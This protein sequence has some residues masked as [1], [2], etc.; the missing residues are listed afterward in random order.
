[1]KMNADLSHWKF[2]L[3][4][5]VLGMIM[6][7]SISV[8][9]KEKASDIFT[10]PKVAELVVAASQGNA[11]EI[12][13]LVAEGVDVNARGENDI[14]PLVFAVSQKNIEGVAR[15]LH[16]G[17]DP[18]LFTYKGRY[19]VM[20]NFV[21]QKDPAYLEL[22][23]DYGGDVNAL[24]GGESLIFEAITLGR[25]EH[26]KILM[27]A[28]ADINF[29][30]VVGATPLHIA[31]YAA[32]YEIAYMLLE[33]GADPGVNNNVGKNGLLHAIEQTQRPGSDEIYQWRQK[34]IEYL[35]AAGMEINPKYP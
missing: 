13:R 23:L 18:N 21:V 5:A 25:I 29:Q 14:T 17:A 30:D 33:A 3:L 8:L 34:V 9:A 27:D 19:S 28:G 22:A 16:H 12:D 7:G 20:W 11:K 31:G 24:S 35:R 1:M 4:L 2:V 10:D 26:V 6:Y 15:L 32:Q